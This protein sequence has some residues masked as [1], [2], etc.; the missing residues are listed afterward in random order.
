MGYCSACK[1]SVNEITGKRSI[2]AQAS[3]NTAG[4]VMPP[5]RFGKAL[6]LAG[7]QQANAPIVTSN[8]VVFSRTS[9][10]RI[11][12]VVPRSEIYFQRPVRE[13]MANERY[14]ITFSRVGSFV[15]H[16][17]CPRAF[18]IEVYTL[19]AKI[20]RQPKERQRC[21]LS[22]FSPHPSGRSARR[23]RDVRDSPQMMSKRQEELSRAFS[24][25]ISQGATQQALGHG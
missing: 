11:E 9:M 24:Q 21:T 13:S 2:N 5:P 4:L 7:R 15:P 3:A 1:S 18:L 10:M 12:P 22:A 14:S 8:Q 20:Y 17:C 19:L 6:F 25:M 23:N 16:G